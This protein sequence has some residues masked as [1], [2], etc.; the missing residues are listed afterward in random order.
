MR[1]QVS[2]ESRN[3]LAGMAGLLY[4]FTILAGMSAAFSES[5][6]YSDIANLIA[7]ICYVVVT[8]L[9]Y[10]LFE[11]VNKPLSLL[12][13]LFSLAGCLLGVLDSLHRNSFPIHNLVF[14]GVYCLLI[15]WLIFQSTFMPRFL[16]VL[17]ALAGLGWLAFLSPK[18]VH[19]L[20]YFP[21]VTGLI[22]EGALTLWLLWAGVRSSSRRE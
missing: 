5:K 11:P 7:T 15:G 9:L 12:A 17:M 13:A 20:S 22:G 2:G 8:L 19:R 6:R 14:F 18:L 1:E 4:L 10:K 16:G 3:R 21:M